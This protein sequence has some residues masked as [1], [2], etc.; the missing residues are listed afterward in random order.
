VIW[1]FK[2]K[3]TSEIITEALEE[4]REEMDLTNDEM[5][6]MFESLDLEKFQENKTKQNKKEKGKE[7]EVTYKLQ[8]EEISEAVGEYLDN[9]L[10]V[11]T[12]FEIVV[13][14]D[15]EEIPLKQIQI[16]ASHEN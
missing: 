8:E 14:I 9:K 5:D 16:K 6:H 2:R 10:D 4:A 13:V 11:G 3:K 1:P 12:D 7:M 15:G